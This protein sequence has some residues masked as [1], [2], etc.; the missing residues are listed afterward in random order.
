M[1]WDSYKNTLTRAMESRKRI[2]RERSESDLIT[3]NRVALLIHVGSLW[4]RYPAPMQA[5]LSRAAMKKGP[6]GPFGA[7]ATDQ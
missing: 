6:E 7:D 4:S 1:N 5:A 3:A 2:N